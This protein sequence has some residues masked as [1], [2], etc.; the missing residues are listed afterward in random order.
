MVGPYTMW[1][2][3]VE[4]QTGSVGFGWFIHYQVKMLGHQIFFF[5]QNFFKF[6]PF[7]YNP[8]KLGGK[9][10]SIWFNYIKIINLFLYIILVYNIHSQCID[11]VDEYSHLEKKCV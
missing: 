1:C 5:S 10:K 3:H 6:I 4:G 7:I 11:Y 8:T 9:K 2:W